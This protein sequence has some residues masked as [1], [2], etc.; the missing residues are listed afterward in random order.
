VFPPS[1]NRDRAQGVACAEIETHALDGIR[2]VVDKV[3]GMGLVAL[4][5]ADEETHAVVEV[6][7]LGALDRAGFVFEDVWDTVFWGRHC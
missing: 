3:R 7:E 5:G 4:G 6:V 2:A 1:A